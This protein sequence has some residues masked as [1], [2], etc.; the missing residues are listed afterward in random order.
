MELVQ[1]RRRTVPFLN[2]EKQ[3]GS[4]DLVNQT[5]QTVNAT[6]KCVFPAKSYSTERHV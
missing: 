3:K 1:K 6:S 4:L 5:R 2:N